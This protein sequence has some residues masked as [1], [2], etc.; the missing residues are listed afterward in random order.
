M[1]ADEE[2]EAAAWVKAETAAAEA[3]EAIGG[4]GMDG[5]WRW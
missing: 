5:G 2:A 4:G 1:G 3:A